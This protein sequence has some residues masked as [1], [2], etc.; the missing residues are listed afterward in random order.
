MP[1]GRT[2]PSVRTDGSSPARETALTINAL[3]AAIID[4]QD[5]VRWVVPDDAPEG[6]GIGY[7]V[8]LGAVADD[9]A[10]VTASPV[11]PT[12][13]ALVYV[14]IAGRSQASLPGSFAVTDDGAAPL[15]WVRVR[16][17]GYDDGGGTRIALA[18]YAARAGSAPDEIEITASCTGASSAVVLVGEVACPPGAVFTNSGAASAPDGSLALVLDEMPSDTSTV[19][20]VDCTLGAY[21]VRPP[22]GFTNAGEI[23]A[24]GL[25][26]G[27]AF[28]NKSTAQE[29]NWKPSGMRT[30]AVAFEVNGSA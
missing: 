17:G 8:T 15:S 13:N 23:V 14:A 4:L 12:A 27:V 30:A 29:F 10:S 11:T 5:R 6:A 21:A 18:V 19:V 2:L 3:R 1:I 20:A 28:S 24:K 7:P 16:A 22:L 25:T 9:G 26:I